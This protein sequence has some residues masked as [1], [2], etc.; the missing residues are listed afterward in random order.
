MAKATH[1]APAEPATPPRPNPLTP[2][3]RETSRVFAEELFKQFVIRKRRQWVAT[4]REERLEKLDEIV[5]SARRRH[6]ASPDGGSPSARRFFYLHHLHRDPRGPSDTLHAP[7]EVDATLGPQFQR[8]PSTRLPVP[9]TPLPDLSIPPR[10]NT[11]RDTLF[12]E[13]ARSKLVGGSSARRQG[14]SD[15]PGGSSGAEQS[16]SAR[17]MSARPRPG[18]ARHGSARS[19][20]GSEVDGPC[21]TARP[22][23]S[24]EGATPPRRGRPRRSSSPSQSDRH[25]RTSLPSPARL[26]PPSERAHDPRARF[27]KRQARADEQSMSVE[28]RVDA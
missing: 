20:L 28:P 1:S 19:K 16:A 8:S 15:R 7:P 3:R 12:P 25:V 9:K 11:P 21:L 5:L 14:G 17:P 13:T 22:A 6:A 2:E 24:P 10:G 23:C 26:P 18:S 4:P 27:M